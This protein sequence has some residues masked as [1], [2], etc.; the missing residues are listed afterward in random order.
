MR[1][2]QTVKNLLN[3]T[4]LWMQLTLF[5]TLIAFSVLFY[6]FYTDYQRNSQI[7]TDTQLSTSERL[8]SMEM[9][10]LEQYIQE[11]SVFTVQSCYDST[12]TRIL[13]RDSDVLPSEETYIKNQIRGYFYSRSD[14]ETFDMYL[15]NHA[16]H[17]SRNHSGVT[18][19]AFDVDTLSDSE[20]FTRCIEGPYF[21]AIMPAEEDDVLFYYYHAL[22]RIKT[23]EPLAI[24]AAAVDH[25]VLSSIRSNHNTSGEFICLANDRDELLYADSFLLSSSSDSILENALQQAE[26]NGSFKCILE[27]VPYLVTYREGSTY[28][29]K[30]YDILPM[31]GIDEQIAQARHSVLV[32]G[33]PVCLALFILMALLI[34]LLTNPLIYLSK[35]MEN[36]GEGDFT[37]SL[38]ISGSSEISNL[39]NSFNSMI[40]HIDQLIR[41][42]Y[43]AEL[44]EKN[45]R[46][47]ALEAQLNP[48]FLYN[49]L[50]AISTEA[51][52]NDQ[53]QIYHMISSL[54]SGLRY[55]IKGGDCVLLK[56]EME[57]VRNYVLLLKMRMD[58]K[59]NVVF[60]IA[61]ETEELFIPKISMQLLVENSV[62]H[63]IGPDRDSISIEIQT[64]VE[65]DILYIIVTD[66]GCGIAEERLQTL[67]D[68][69][70]APDFAS[71]ADDIGLANLYGRLQLFYH[72]QADLKIETEVGKMTKITLVIPACK[73]APHV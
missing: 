72:K 18:S 54:A 44:N 65:N 7:I 61:P 12:F 10:N 37:T 46:I 62:I 64:Y 9:E 11:L 20:L 35:K 57:Y 14:L 49:T 21:Q 71:H 51:L 63:G 8:L 42:N 27:G 19:S 13:E 25:S 22:I 73:E 66:D 34:R 40:A 36:V 48:H 55:T 47:T 41:Q 29:M 30:L 16:L 67:L 60:R 5:T 32:S 45:A 6:L 58:D 15:L 39:S 50:Q 3:H 4:P 70:G 24:T 53:M 31:S 69:F 1:L 26:K 2:R 68:S 38:N 56:Q 52:V 28:H 33:V 23:K 17:F 43:L 59:L